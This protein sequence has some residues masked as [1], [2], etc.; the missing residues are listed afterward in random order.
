MRLCFLSGADSIHSQKWIKYFADKGQEVHWISLAPN[1]F[2]NIKNVRFYL[3]KRF[4]VKPLD[5]IFNVL[6][7]R[8]LLKKINPD[9]FHVHYAGVNGAI[10]ALSG[11]HPFILTA[12]GSDILVT[13]KS[14]IARPLIKFALNKANL[15]TCNSEILKQEV[16]KLSN[17]PL[18]IKLIYWGT[19]IQEFRP[20][21]ENKKIKERL[22]ITDSPVI[23]SLRNLEP[24][25]DVK[26]L[27]ESIPLVLK[28]NPKAKFIIAGRGSEEEKLKK[29]AER[30]KIL[31]NV[32]F[33]GWISS[34][35]VLR[36]LRS[37]DI[38]V[39]TSLSDGDLSQGTQQ[40]MA[41]EL[42]II[43]TDIGVNKKRIKDKENGLLA[44]IRNPKLLSKKIILL[45]KNEKLRIKLG[46]A[47]RKTIETELNYRKEMEKAGKLYKELI[48]DFK[49][50]NLCK[51]I[52]T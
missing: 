15:I 2:G 19:D 37:S 49:R 34:S 29:L 4:S 30:L 8:K 47:G 50:N 35:D 31:E 52:E 20:G 43:T 26:T 27:I 11:F 51:K 42:P 25:Y 28:K 46:K 12:W 48:G 3:M 44:P 9:I 13:S 14:K 36:Y 32:K 38:L 16:I 1:T 39:S 41:C 23:I 21:P 22:K 5:V 40:A 10:G 7:I 33:I 18:K 6:P 24:I 17:N 45:L